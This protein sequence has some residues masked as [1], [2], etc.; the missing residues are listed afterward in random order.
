ME[1]ILSK[2]LS[3]GTRAAG[4]IRLASDQ[5]TNSVLASGSREQLAEVEAL[6]NRL[7]TPE[8]GKAPVKK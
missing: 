3:I 7:D 6:L 4:A 8:G 1:R 2:L 5:R